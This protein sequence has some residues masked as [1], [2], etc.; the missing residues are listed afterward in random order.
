MT[1]KEERPASLCGALSFELVVS[2]YLLS[3]DSAFTRSESFDPML[4]KAMFENFISK[5][6]LPD[7]GIELGDITSVIVSNFSGE[8]LIQLT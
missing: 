8:T 6:E 7:F 3:I 4:L 5:L 1:I 2:G